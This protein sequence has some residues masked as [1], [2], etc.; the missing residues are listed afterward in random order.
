[1][2]SGVVLALALG[3]GSA[4]YIPA[5]APQP[6]V[7]GDL[8]RHPCVEHHKIT[9][10]D[11]IELTT[12]LLIPYPCDG[13][14]PAVM[15]RTPY[16]PTLDLIDSVY[17][18]F[19]FTA[20]LQNQ[21]G[22]FTSGGDYDFWKMDG[23]DSYDT[24]VWFANHSTYNGE[25]FI[26]GASADGCSAIADW[27]FPGTSDYIK[28]GNYIWA[29]GFGHETS[30]WGGAYRED[31]ISHWLLTLDTCANS[32]NIE[33]EV[34]E[35]EAYG[36]W[37]APLEANGPYGNNLVN[38]NAPQ[39]SQAGW[40]DIFL[41]GQID[42]FDGTIEY[43]EED[44]QDKQWLWIIPGGHCTG[45]EATF[46]YP[47]FESLQDFP[48][49]AQ[50]MFKGNWDANCFQVSDRYNVYVMGPVPFY[51]S[52][53]ERSNHTGNY[54]TSFPS[55][56]TTTPQ[57]WFLGKEGL[58]SMTSS[59]VTTAPISYNYD[60]SNPCP[61]VG[62]NTLYSS[63]PC[64]PHDQ[65]DILDRSDVISW[66]AAEAFTEPVGMV[67]KV[68]AHLT[69]SSSAVDTD[70]YV[71]LVDQYPDDGPLVNV[72]YGAVKMRWNTPDATPEVAVNMVPDQVYEV[73]VDM[74][75]TAYIW[76]PGHTLGVIVTSSRSPE[77]T[78]NPNNGLPIASQSDGDMIIA[79]NTI[80]CG[81]GS[82]VT[83]PIVSLQD[84]Q[85]NPNIR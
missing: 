43:C 33:Q 19:G 57:Q 71:T 56:P 13:Q 20:I 80:Y 7:E 77:F 58:A 18:P 59:D 65:S 3:F 76:N 4:H 63:T 11:G 79:N 69:V 45:D 30:Y 8:I 47:K 22:C 26:S 78:V 23:S 66:S 83:L 34:R 74:W 42:T 14:Y 12:V 55:W 70:F 5:F 29:T 67:G 54:W 85:L 41:Q 84:I 24:M 17:T 44:V 35:N 37:W 21:R 9:T 46:G 39:I 32:D 27:A 15:D 6:E 73:D 62:A 68:S 48:Y 36:E 50:E 16:G 28:G 40:W 52:D 31:L 82:Y 49:M 38:V 25:I 2:L 60:P 81:E 1:M 53:T 10:S 64:G 72:R 51:M 75:T 61:A